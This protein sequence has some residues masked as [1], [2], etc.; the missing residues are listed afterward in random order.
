MWELLSVN[1]WFLGSSRWG[2]W[3]RDWD[4]INRH[5]SLLKSATSASACCEIGTMLLEVSL[6]INHFSVNG[7]WCFERFY[8][9]LQT[10]ILECYCFLLLVVSPFVTIFALWVV[11]LRHWA[12][13]DLWSRVWNSVRYFNFQTQCSTM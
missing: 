4:L 9:L 11:V 6:F 3:H 13:L 12:I 8:I 1:M 7:E 5:N 2:Q 10:N